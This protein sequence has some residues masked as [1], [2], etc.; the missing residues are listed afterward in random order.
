M[1]TELILGVDALAVAITAAVIDVRQH[2]IPNWVTYPGI[3]MGILLRW[4]FLG[5]RGLGSALTG[6]LIAGG[7]MLVFYLVRAMGAGD[8]KLLAA[9]GSLVG[10]SHAVVVLI[11]TAIAGGVLALVYVLARRRFGHHPQECWLG[12]DVSFLERLEVPSGIESG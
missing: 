4:F 7:V 10:P 1:N 11:A 8:V 2:R 6:C 12:A 3:A 5:W 9:I